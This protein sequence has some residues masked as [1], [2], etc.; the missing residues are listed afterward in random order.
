MT[1][2]LVSNLVYRFS[3]TSTTTYLMYS[4]QFTE[5]RAANTTLAAS[6]RAATTRTMVE[7]VRRTRSRHGHLLVIV[8]YGFQ[9]SRG[10]GGSGIAGVE[11]SSAVQ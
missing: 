7:E 9:G 5:G 1:V 3:W 10:S 6:A 4:R 11:R 2:R 8:L